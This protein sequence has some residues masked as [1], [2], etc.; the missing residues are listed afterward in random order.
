MDEM[1]E[2]R[3]V[4]FYILLFFLLSFLGWLWEGAIYLVTA[5]EFVNRGIYKGPYLPV[6]GV[7]G[8]LLWFL[9]HR[10]SR[11]PVRTFLLS[12]L[13]CSVLEYMT[14]NFLEWRWGLRW[15]DYS[16]YFMNLNGY[17]CLLSAAAFGLAGVVL[18]C[19]LMPL[20]MK[21]YHKVPEKWRIALS[22]LLLA[23]IIADATYCAVRPQTGENITT[24]KI[25][26]K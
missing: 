7:G 8:L 6:Y 5:H 26:Y 2:Q 16:G 25:D 17:I 3:R 22:L 4:D 24:G 1:K 23:I 13:I 20:Y 12:A 19:L 21:V 15:W 14:G 10:F 18:N 9:L 11:K